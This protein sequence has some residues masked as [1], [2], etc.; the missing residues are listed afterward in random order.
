ML[1]DG[2]ADQGKRIFASGQMN[3]LEGFGQMQFQGTK[4]GNVKADAIFATTGRVLWIVVK[5]MLCVIWV[6]STSLGRLP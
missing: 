1:V 3:E 4:V 5:K 6:G 2:W